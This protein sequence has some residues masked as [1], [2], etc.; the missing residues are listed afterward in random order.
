MPRNCFKYLMIQIFI[1]LF[2][3]SDNGKAVAEKIIRIHVKK[4][5]NNHKRVK[6]L[7]S[8]QDK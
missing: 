3:K 2:N 8:R 4:V 6:G 7:K 5:K 1:K